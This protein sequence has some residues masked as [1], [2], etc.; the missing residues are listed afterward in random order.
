MLGDCTLQGNLLSD[1]LGFATFPAGVN[2]TRPPNAGVAFPPIAVAE[3]AANFDKAR[4]IAFHCPTLCATGYTTTGKGSGSTLANVPIKVPPGS[5]VSYET[6]AP[7]KQRCT[8]AG[9]STNIISF[10]LTNEAGEPIEA[11]GD[12]FEALIVLETSQ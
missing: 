4:S 3:S 1:L 12:T 10:F 7:I 5:V 8:L 6:P 11:L 9:G 2:F